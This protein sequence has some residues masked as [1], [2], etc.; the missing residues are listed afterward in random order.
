MNKIN[1]LNTPEST[2]AQMVF[3][4]YLTGNKTTLEAL[5]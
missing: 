3:Y 4:T 1:Q 5:K 2:G